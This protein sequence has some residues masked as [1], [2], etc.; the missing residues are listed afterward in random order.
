MDTHCVDDISLRNTKEVVCVWK[1]I[2]RRYHVIAILCLK[3]IIIIK[4]NY[5][6][7]LQVTQLVY[8]LIIIEKLSAE[9]Y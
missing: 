7:Y 3:I 9:A 2:S 1:S 5:T 4:I 8:N 6:F